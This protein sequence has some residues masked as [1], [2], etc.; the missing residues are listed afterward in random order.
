MVSIILYNLH[1]SSYSWWLSER[2][3]VKS[4]GLQAQIK[5]SQIT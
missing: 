4:Y 2:V 3:G 5:S 1:Q